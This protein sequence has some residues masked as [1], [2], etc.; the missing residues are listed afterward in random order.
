MVKRKTINDDEDVFVIDL[1]G[2]GHVN[3][4]NYLEEHHSL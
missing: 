3:S 4:G 1:D 2:H